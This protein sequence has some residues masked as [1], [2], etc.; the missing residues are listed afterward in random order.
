[1]PRSAPALA[2]PTRCPL[3][4]RGNQCAMQ[5]GVPA[6]ECWCM[7]ATVAPQALA[8]LAPEQR[9]QACLCPAC[10]AGGAPPS[11]SA[12]DGDDAGDAGDAGGPIDRTDS[13]D[14]ADSADM[15]DR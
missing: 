9:G 1:M 10:A 2:D 13:A 8:A 15:I 4:G 7:A 14:S 3:C 6:S 12:G 11:E 5:A